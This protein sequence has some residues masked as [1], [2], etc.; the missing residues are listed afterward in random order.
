MCSLRE[1]ESF[2]YSKFSTFRL[3]TEAHA[4]FVELGRRMEE[5]GRDPEDRPSLGISATELRHVAQ[6]AALCEIRLLDLFA[7]TT[8][9]IDQ[10]A[11]TAVHHARQRLQVLVVRI[12]SQPVEF[13][14]IKHAVDVEMLI[15][16]RDRCPAARA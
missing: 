16:G 12:R 4:H 9:R 7:L 13:G 2:I 5:M 3:Q 6:I 1:N 8:P 11:A 10:L 15:L 14:G